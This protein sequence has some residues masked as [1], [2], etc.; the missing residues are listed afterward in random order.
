MAKAA[1]KPAAP[2]VE[3]RGEFSLVLDGA[4]YGL[5]PSYEA[6]EA[7]EAAT[8]QGLIDL[9]RA[10]LAA[11]LSLAVTSQVATEFIR[12]WGRANG[13]KGASGA[14]APRIAKLILNSDGGFHAALQTLSGVLSL[15]VTGGFDAEGEMKPSTTPNPAKEARVDG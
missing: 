3:D 4:T 14:N 15:A 10:G 13:D 12:A 8:G 11:K 2:I 9:A 7:V 5:R 6:I 1:S